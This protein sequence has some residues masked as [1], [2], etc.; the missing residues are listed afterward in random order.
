M[1]NLL[2]TNKC[3]IIILISQIW[4]I[5]LYILN[6]YL[7]YNFK[8]F[9]NIVVLYSCSQL[10]CIKGKRVAVN[11]N[12]IFGATWANFVQCAS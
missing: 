5:A 7:I 3:I 8:R 11:E 2:L 4:Y 10:I 9:Q 6:I 1:P 12:N